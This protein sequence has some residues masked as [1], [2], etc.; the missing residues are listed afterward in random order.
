MMKRFLKREPSR[1][2]VAEVAKKVEGEKYMLKF[3]LWCCAP[4]MPPSLS[5]HTHTHTHTDGEKAMGK[6]VV[7]KADRSL[8]F[9]DGTQFTKADADKLGGMDK[10]R[11]RSYITF[12]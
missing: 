9:A 7:I 5:P 12:L 4:S 11:V 10:I 1:A 3:K 6:Q 8:I 2:E